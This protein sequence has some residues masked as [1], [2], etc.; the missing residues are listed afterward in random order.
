M[1]ENA[2]DDVGR[3][4][5][6]YGARLGQPLRPYHVP[7]ML[8]RFCKLAEVCRGPGRHK[9]ATPSMRRAWLK[10]ADDWLKLARANEKPPT[11]PG[12]EARCIRLMA[13]KRSGRLQYFD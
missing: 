10:L 5:T 7:K 6:P 3:T 13:T 2:A 11:V 4:G 1:I 8:V 9:P 12:Y